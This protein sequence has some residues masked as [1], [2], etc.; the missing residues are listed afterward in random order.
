PHPIDEPP[1]DD[2]PALIH[3]EVD[4]LADRY[5]LPVVLCYLEGK[6]HEEAARVLG[7]PLG[8]VKGRLA[9]ARDLLR[10]RLTRR[11]LTL[12]AAG[13]GTALAENATAAVPPALLGLTLRAAVSFAAGGAS[14]GA[15]ASAGALAL[16]KGAL[17]TM[18]ATKWL[19]GA[20]VAAAVA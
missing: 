14:G 20:V 16:A 18:P 4:R 3:E 6:T 9:R 1:A 15:A 5:R 13:V 17:P 8:S 11:G 19:W 2:R 10:T 7:W 12:T